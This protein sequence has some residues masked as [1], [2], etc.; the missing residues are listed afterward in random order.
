MLVAF[1]AATAMAR[2]RFTGARCT[3]WGYG[4][5]MIP[6]EALVIPM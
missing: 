1:L 5:Q 6:L 2:F 3:W 4:I